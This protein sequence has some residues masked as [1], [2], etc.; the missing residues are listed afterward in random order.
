[1]NSGMITRRVK[2]M[3][4]EAEKDGNSSVYLISAEGHDADLDF[5]EDRFDGFLINYSTALVKTSDPK[6]LIEETEILLNGY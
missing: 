6:K 1:M 3:F 4:E 5:L 2:T